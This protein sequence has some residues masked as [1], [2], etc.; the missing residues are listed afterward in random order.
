METKTSVREQLREGD[1]LNKHGLKRRKRGDLPK[2]R[3]WFDFETPAPL[4]HQ[5]IEDALIKLIDRRREHERVPRTETK[6]IA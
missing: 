3:A 2:P 5:R 4:R 1:H 6:T